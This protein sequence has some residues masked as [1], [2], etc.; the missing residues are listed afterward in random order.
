MKIKKIFA[1]L[2][3]HF[4]KKV[5]NNRIHIIGVN[6]RQYLVWYGILFVLS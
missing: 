1:P 4:E 2:N 5:S 6:F 3:H